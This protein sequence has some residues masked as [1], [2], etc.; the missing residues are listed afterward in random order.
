MNTPSG[1]ATNWKH[2]VTGLLLWCGFTLLLIAAKLSEFPSAGTRIVRGGRMSSPTAT[3]LVRVTAGNALV[4]GGQEYHSLV[5]WC[6]SV[7]QTPRQPVVIAAHPKAQAQAVERVVQW[8]Q[9]RG[10]RRVVVVIDTSEN[11]S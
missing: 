8:L 5:E 4:S 10:V 6:R 9:S 7:R 11:G 1:S 3:P 2:I